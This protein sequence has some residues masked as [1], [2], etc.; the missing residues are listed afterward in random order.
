M[1]NEIEEEAEAM[2]GVWRVAAEVM[3]PTRFYADES[4]RLYYDEARTK[5]TGLKLQ[6]LETDD[7]VIIGT[8]R[9]TL[10]E[11]LRLGAVS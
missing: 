6:T 10:G 3:Y 2:D 1:D 4:G 8:V 5:R 7:G 9:E 11:V